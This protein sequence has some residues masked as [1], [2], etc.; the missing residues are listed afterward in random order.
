MS[1]ACPAR[2]AMPSRS[3]RHSAAT[4]GVTEYILALAIM[5][6]HSDMLAVLTNGVET[7]MRSR[8]VLASFR[9]SCEF[10]EIRADQ[11]NEPTYPAMKQ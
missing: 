8:A 1:T 9:L 2:S 6:P 4:A 7:W 3:R 10:H 5:D 11:K